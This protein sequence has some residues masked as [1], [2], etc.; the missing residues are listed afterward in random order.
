MLGLRIIL[1][2][3][4]VLTLDLSFTFL[5]LSRVPPEALGVAIIH[6]A[7]R[8]AQTRLFL[9]ILIRHRDPAVGREPTRGALDP[10]DLHNASDEPILTLRDQLRVQLRNHIIEFLERRI[11]I[12]RLSLRSRLL[13]SIMR[14]ASSALRPASSDPIHQAPYTTHNLLRR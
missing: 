10:Q 2:R 3:T 12:E 9:A 8:S 11:R 4:L 14:H 6:K 13:R 5:W 7:D 1:A